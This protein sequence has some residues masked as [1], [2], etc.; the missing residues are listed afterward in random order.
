[1]AAS[2]LRPWHPAPRQAPALLC[3][4]PA[5]AG[6][7]QYRPWQD[8]LGDDVSVIGVALPGRESRW[9]DPMPGTL[10]E[11]VRQIAAEADALLAPG[12]PWT[13]FGESFGGLLGFEV[14]RRLAADYGRL[15]EALVV[16]ACRAPHRWVGAGTGLLAADDE[17]EKLLAARDLDPELLD[18]E[19]R[20]LMLE[21]LRADVELSLTYR[22][23][24]RV[25]LPCT[26]RGLGRAGRHHR[27]RRPPRRMGRL[28]GRL[29][30]AG[31]PGGHYFCTPNAPTTSPPCCGCS[32]RKGTGMRVDLLDPDLFAANA[33]WP[34]L[35]HLR[36]AGSG[37]LAR[38]PGRRGL[39]GDHPLRGHR[40]RLHGPRVLQLPATACGWTATPRRCPPW[41]SGCSSSPTRREYTRLKRVPVLRRLRPQRDA[42]L[43][44]TGPPGGPR[45][46]RRGPGP[47]SSTLSTSPNRCPTGWSAPSWASP[48]GPGDGS[49]TRH[50]GPRGSRR[51]GEVRAHS[52]IFL[53]FSDLLDARR[54][55][56]GED[57]LSR[58]AAD[59]ALPEE[60]GERRPSPTRRSSSNCN[61]GTGRRERDDALFGGRGVLAFMEN[62]GQWDLLRSSPGP[63]AIPAAVEEILRWTV[64]GVH[65]MRT[66]LRPARIGDTEFAPATGSPCGT[67]PPT[68]T[69]QCSR[70]RLL[71]RPAHP[72]PAPHLRRR[73]P[74]VPRRPAG[75]A[76]TGGSLRGVDRPGEGVPA[77]RRGPVQCL[78]LHLGRAACRSPSPPA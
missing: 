32:P 46:R 21:T 52:E 57:F 9:S 23:P 54:K 4:A 27:H 30:P 72:E 10:D 51:T 65:A 14:V 75:P 25:V 1:M 77:H 68:A 69:S 53:Y 66:V 70:P 36:A 28:R 40:R 58:I 48:R 18:A 47:V 35:R 26:R 49:G 37:P 42:P 44:S 33:F 16:A 78:E 5:G 15:P 62:P 73:P 3:L 67:P 13:V 12:Q 59:G 31:V 43:R 60:T 29:P 45:D 8:L 50:R 61:R 74:P 39:L 22:H 41:R 17:L 6:C 76:R 71:P 24:G 63:E 20:E 11:A 64:P 55:S 38:P 19:T 2:W 34:T 56:P 7:G